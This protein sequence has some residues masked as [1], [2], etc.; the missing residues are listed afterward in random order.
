MN[1]RQAASIGALLFAVGC[2]EVVQQ[3]SASGTQTYQG[4][5]AGIEVKSTWEV[6]SDGWNADRLTKKTLEITTPQPGAYMIEAWTDCYRCRDQ[7]S[8][9]ES[10]V[11]PPETK[12]LT[13]SFDPGV[14]RVEVTYSDGKTIERFTH[15]TE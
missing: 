9:I 11:V 2:K 10:V 12:A 5:R 1:W 7:L 6:T 3:R 8:S 14:Y 15:Y 13:R 4:T